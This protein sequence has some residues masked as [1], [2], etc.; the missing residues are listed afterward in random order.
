M[1]LRSCRR[2]Y[3]VVDDTAY[4]ATEVRRYHDGVYARTPSAPRLHGDHLIWVLA[5]DGCV[6][7]VGVVS[8]EPEL[9]YAADTGLSLFIAEGPAADRGA[10]GARGATSARKPRR[11]S[12][13]GP[14]AALGP[15]SPLG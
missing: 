12:P 8:V 3:I 6:L 5:E 1:S 15:P 14:V 9:A 2:G 7:G 4:T 10:P 11:S 13:P